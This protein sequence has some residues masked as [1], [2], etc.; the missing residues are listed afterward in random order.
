MMLEFLPSLG[1]L[2]CYGSVSATSKK[3]INAI[4]RHKSIVYAYVVL[5][6]LLFLGA[7]ILQIGLQFPFG[8]LPAYI[9]QIVLGGLG[10]ISAYKALD[11]G[12]S[13][14][15]SPVA[16][17]YVLLVLAMSIIF[18]GE[19]LSAGQIG[20]SVLIV[21]SAFVIALERKGSFKLEKW[22]I[23]LGISILCRAYYYTFIKTFVVA[24]GAYEATLI[25]ELGVASFV[26]AFHALRGRDLSPPP[27]EKIN[28]PAAAGALIF[29]GSLLY[30]FSVSFIGAALTAAISAGAP[31]VNAVASYLLLGEKL[32][33]HKYAAIVLL[34]VGLIA[35]FLL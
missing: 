21:V 14:I 31:M 4:G 33:A 16:R 15:T 10:A 34:V 22:M 26:V 11:Y 18:L 3:A 7:I 23:Y 12:K 17:I 24:L 28:Y 27:L 5:V 25:L 13:S 29:F 1:S 20:G 35:I 6:T 32:D 2:L 19:E 30:S 8:L 9:A